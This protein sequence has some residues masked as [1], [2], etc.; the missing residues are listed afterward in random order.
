M[1]FLSLIVC[2][3]FASV[4]IGQENVS[5][6]EAEKLL[7]NSEVQL[8]D[9]RTPEEFQK[10]YIPNALQANWL[11]KKE[12]QRRVESVDKNKPVLVYCAT[13]GRSSQ[14][15]KWLTE[16][17]FVNVYN[18]EGGFTRWKQENKAVSA[19]GDTSQM[20]LQSYDSLINNA[21]NKIVLVDF[22][23]EWCAPCRKMK[24]V[25]E[26]LKKDVADEFSLVKIDGGVQTKV[27]NQ[28]GVQNLPTFIVYKNGK[29]VWREEG[30]VELNELKAQVSK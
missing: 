21:K 7:T 8:L 29:E 10:G 1:K 18:L 15:A 6:N 25:L 19:F 9:V 24:P 3:F 4:V 12:F 16:N 26:Q 2:L 20:S 27:M 11:D 5:T 23:A 17:G 28:L 22:G 30:I 14:A 13:G